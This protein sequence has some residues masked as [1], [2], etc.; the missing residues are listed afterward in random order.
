MGPLENDGQSNGGSNSISTRNELLSAPVEY[1]AKPAKG[2]TKLRTLINNNIILN[3]TKTVGDPTIA[4][5][6]TMINTNTTKNTEEQIPQRADPFTATG[7]G[8]QLS[9]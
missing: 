9:I 8:E 2:S 3:A 6:T 4:E 5:T 1:T 7:E